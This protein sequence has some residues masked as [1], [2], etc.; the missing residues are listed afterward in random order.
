M[1]SY[2][3]ETLGHVF[4]GLFYFILFLGGAVRYHRPGT[5]LSERV[6]GL[7]PS[8]LMKPLKPVPLKVEMDFF[9]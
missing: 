8:P 1:I 6:H 9:F 5:P 3:A 2:R 7:I 4:V